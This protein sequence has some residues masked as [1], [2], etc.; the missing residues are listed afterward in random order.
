[1][2]PLRQTQTWSRSWSLVVLIAMLLPSQKVHCLAPPHPDFVDFEGVHAYRRRMNIT[3]GYRPVHLSDEDCRFLSEE[4]CQREDEAHIEAKNRLMVE[5]EH[6]RRRLAPS[7]G[8]FRV[9]VMLCRFKDHTNVQLPPKEHFEELFNGKGKSDIN[10][11]GSIA[12]YLYYSSMGKYKVTFDIQDWQ[13]TDR[14]ESYYAKGTGGR[15]GNLAMQEVFTPLLE[16]LDASMS[17]SESFQFW[18]QYDRGGD[19]VWGGDGILD[20]LVVIH[21]GYPAEQGDRN[22]G[23]PSYLDRIWSQGSGSSSGGW[24]NQDGN[25]RLGGYTLASA[26]AA[27]CQTLPN[28]MGIITHEYLHA[29]FLPDLY[30]QDSNDEAVAIGGVGSYDIMANAYGWDRQSAYPGSMSAYSRVDAGWLDPIEITT[31]GVYAIQPAEISSQVYKI[32][33]PYPFG[34]YLLIEN[35]QPI[36]WNKWPAGGIVITHV[37]E[38]KPN[39]GQRGYPGKSGWPAEHYRVAI[40]QKDGLYQLEKGDNL[41][42]EGDFFVEGDVLGPG[43]NKF[44]NTDAYSSGRAI[45]TGLTIKVLSRPGFIMSFEVSGLGGSAPWSP[46]DGDLGS[47]D[48]SAVA[49]LAGEGTGDAMHWVFGL[50]GG[51]GLVIGIA[52]VLL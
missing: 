35:R 12:S 3:Y 38:Q 43:P 10:P 46:P 44:P 42:D 47:I 25:F 20:Q 17:R 51:L 2:E 29:F 32:A 4:E 26:W 30:D 18:L 27:V 39:Q 37:D 48:P 52:V 5:G 49:E 41:G 50:I 11:I 15:N 33:S 16:R 6:G 34:E 19:P 14:E 9:M 1:M 36:K 13:T 7:E 28:T 40:Q 45:R 24:Q 21:S 8:E 31:D 22:C 23:H